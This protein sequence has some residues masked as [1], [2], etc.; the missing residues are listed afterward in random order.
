[1]SGLKEYLKERNASSIVRTPMALHGVEVRVGNEGRLSAPELKFLFYKI[2]DMIAPMAVSHVKQI[3]VSTFPSMKK[4]D[5]KS[6]YKDGIMY[7]SSD[8]DYIEEMMMNFFH[9]LAHSFEKP[10][11]DKIY[12]DGLLEIEFRN[13]RQKLKNVITMYEGGMTPPFDFSQINYNKELDH[14]LAN[15]IGYDKLWQYCNGIFTNPYAATSLR[16]YFASGF[17]NYVK[18]NSETLDRFCP[19]LYNKVR[20]FF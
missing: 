14:Y 19:V 18:N 4:E 6:Y 2:K 12:G 1:M 20:Q 15:T 16:E 7:L 17:E 3:K 10:H 5:Y 8:V 9:E 11:Y 13:K